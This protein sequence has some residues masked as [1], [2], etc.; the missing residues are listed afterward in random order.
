ML[1]LNIPN[2]LP[3]SLKW[4]VLTQLVLLFFVLSLFGIFFDKNA[5]FAVF[6]FA[7]LFLG[8]P[9][10]IYVMISNKFISFVITENTITIN[11]GIVF[12]R[13]NTIA[14]DQVQNADNSRGPLSTFFGL[15]KLSIWTASPS[16]MHIE[17]GRSENKPE[18]TLW[19]RTVD[20]DE[21]KDFILSKKHS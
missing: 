1:P 18:G 5:W 4:Y 9:I 16:Q 8:L 7:L 2:K 17:K 19:L 6:Y 12:K 20:A 10:W 11:S 14:F 13:S 3:K 15:S 21:L